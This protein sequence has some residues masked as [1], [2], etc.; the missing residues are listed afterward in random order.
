[1]G[2]GVGVEV[3]MGVG[4]GVTI[5]KAVRA[6]SQGEIPAKRCDV[7]RISISSY[8]VECVPAAGY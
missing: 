6:H 7:G 8:S 1:M 3:G 4:V 2:V 5:S